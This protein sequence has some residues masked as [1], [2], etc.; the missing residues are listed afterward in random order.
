MKIAIKNCFSRAGTLW[1]LWLLL[2]IVIFQPNL[3]GQTITVTP[4]Q[5]FSATINATTVNTTAPYQLTYLLVNSGGTVVQSNT[6]GSFTGVAAGS[7]TIYAINHDSTDPTAVIPVVGNTYAA[8]AGCSTELSRLVQ[9]QDCVS[10]C[11]GTTFDVPAVASS[12]LT[13]TYRLDYVL[14]CGTTITVNAAAADA[15]MGSTSFT[16]PATPQTCTLYAVNYDNAAGTPTYS[17]NLTVS[18]NT[19]HT[20]ID[21]CVNITNVAITLTPTNPICGALSSGS[22]LVSGLT[23]NA[24]GYTVAYAGVTSGTLSNQTASAMGEINNK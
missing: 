24:T 22:I 5:G 15:T 2:S 8:P 20:F 11:A 3:L 18:G 23:P 13:G 10:A 4:N 21:R 6:T 14:V 17:G 1:G 19:C 12:N 9:V 16:A 7:Y